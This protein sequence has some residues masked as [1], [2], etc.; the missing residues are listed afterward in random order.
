MIYYNA[1]YRQKFKK[2]DC[3]EDLGTTEEYI[4]PAAQYVSTVSQSD[5]D[6]KAKKDAEE[7]GQKF[8]NN[9]GGCCNVYYNQRVEGDF[10]KNDCPEGMKQEVPTHYVVEAGRFHS[11]ESVED[12]NREAEEAL[13]SEGQ[14]AANTS[15]ECKTIYW[16]ER[17]HGWYKKACGEGWDS[18]ER[19]RTISEGTVY[20]FISV[21]DANRIAKEKLDE[22]SQQ[23]VDENEKCEPVT[24]PCSGGWE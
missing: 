23:W 14:A 13:A 11:T 10:Y 3:P 5:A 6:N 19:Y 21:E 15:G 2:N 9:V 8:A 17:Q 20:S 7:N 24:D 12:A 4:V 18:K 1:E 16:N 22:E